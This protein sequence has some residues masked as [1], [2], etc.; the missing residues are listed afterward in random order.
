MSSRPQRWL[1]V[2][3]GLSHFRAH[4]PTILLAPPTPLPRLHAFILLSPSLPSLI[5]FIWQ[6]IIF[7][8]WL[9][10]IGSSFSF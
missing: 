5:I 8:A 3:M 6:K 2:E 1:E 10:H 9:G 4:I 7:P